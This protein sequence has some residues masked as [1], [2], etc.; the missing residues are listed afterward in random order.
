MLLKIASKKINA[1]RTYNNLRHDI[2]SFLG[3]Q[4]MDPIKVTHKVGDNLSKEDVKYLKN[5]KKNFLKEDRDTFK[6]L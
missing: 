5:I 1:T 4:D 2:T 6:Y 3:V